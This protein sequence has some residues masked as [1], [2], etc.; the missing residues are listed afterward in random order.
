MLSSSSRANDGTLGLL[1]APV[2]TTT[3]S[4]TQRVLATC[5]LESIPG[6]RQSVDLDPGSDRELERAGIGLQIVG[7]LVLG[8]ICPGRSRKR[9]PRQSVVT[10]GRKQTQRIPPLPPGITD[11]LVLVQDD[12]RQTPVALR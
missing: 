7:G 6:L 2:A 11:A 3:F 10:A 5:H 4:A 1:N 8:R 9:H 12:E